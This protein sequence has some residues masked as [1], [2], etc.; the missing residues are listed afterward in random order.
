M[1]PRRARSGWE[2]DSSLNEHI[3][4][5]LN[6]DRGQS[7]TITVC[8]KRDTL[9]TQLYLIWTPISVPISHLSV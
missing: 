1:A 3:P 5:L 4:T 7:D 6:D 8:R 2:M 9:D